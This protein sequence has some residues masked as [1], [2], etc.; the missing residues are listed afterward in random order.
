MA[1]REEFSANSENMSKF[2]IKYE[3]ALNKYIRE[4]RKAAK[5]LVGYE[6]AEAIRDY[7]SRDS[8]HPHPDYTFTQMA[9]NRP[10]D[11]QFPVD[12]MRDMAH[13]CALNEATNEVT[14]TIPTPQ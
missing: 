4:A 1:L 6:R 7:F 3:K 11:Y 10:S 12:L 13:L 8:D 9:M 2:D 14:Q 5:G